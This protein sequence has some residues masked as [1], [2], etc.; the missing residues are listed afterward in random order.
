VRSL[1]WGRITALVLIAIGGSAFA[2]PHTLFVSNER[3]DNITLIDGESRTVVATV[4]V[5]K[6]P[7]GVQLS[8]DGSRVY[9]A[10]SGSPR[11]GPGVDPERAKSLKA[12]K[13]ADGIAMLERASLRMIRKLSVGSDPEQFALS[14]DGR[15]LFVSNE[16]EAAASCWEIESGRNIFR[17]TVSD[18]PEGVGL[19]PTRNEVYITCE[20]RGEVYALD[21]KS[22]ATIAKWVVG[23]RPRTV[24]F[25]ADGARA[26]VP[27]E[28]KAQVAIIDAAAH[29]VLEP[30]AIEGRGVMPMCGLVSRDGRELYVSTGRG[31]TVVVLDLTANEQVASIGVGERPWGI[32]LSPDGTLLYS[33]NGASDDVSV[34]DVKARREL[35]R[36]K[37]GAGPWGLAIGVK[38]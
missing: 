13:A 37:V 29:R 19:H 6:R 3:S 5:G 10:L 2:T 28:G 30:I 16:D 38:R 7:R 12:D 23:G 17:A 31:N 14:R 20:E 24:A 26:Y 11:L 1:S 32:A 25:S 22:G 9:V 34:I 4:P 21:A 15:T 8:P 35:T 36:I 27:L 33:A 18:E